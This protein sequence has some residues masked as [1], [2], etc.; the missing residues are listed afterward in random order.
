MRQGFSRTR[1][2]PLKNAFLE[3]HVSLQCGTAVVRRCMYEYVT[4]RV[5]RVRRTTTPRR[6][7]A[8]NLS[9]SLSLALFLSGRIRGA[10]RVMDETTAR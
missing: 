6:I 2:S 3:M 10:E 5:T 1:A 8:C 7:R 4:Q 9:L